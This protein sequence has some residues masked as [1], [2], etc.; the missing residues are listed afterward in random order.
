MSMTQTELKK[1]L[2]IAAVLLG[3]GLIAVPFAIYWVGQQLIGEYT[4]D[5]GLLDLA[6][7]IWWD[8]LQ[9]RV[10]AWTLVLSPYLIVQLG[11]LTR[12]AW[13]RP[14]L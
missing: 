11:R 3:F 4:P 13:R 8:L 14:A 1:E 12:F 7:S 10:S 5:G 9:L 2:T 6:E